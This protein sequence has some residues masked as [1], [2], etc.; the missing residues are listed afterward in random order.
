MLALME[1]NMRIESEK[2]KF[3]VRLVDKHIYNGSISRDELAKHL[4]GLEDSSD[5]CEEL[6]LEEDKPQEEETQE[7]AVEEVQQEAPKDEIT[8]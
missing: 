3:D 8:L 4:K 5:L 2:K 6:S 7:E 1:E